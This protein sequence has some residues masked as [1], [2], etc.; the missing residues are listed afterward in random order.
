M[1]AMGDANGVV[2]EYEKIKRPVTINRDLQ[3]TVCAWHEFSCHV[4]DDLK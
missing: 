4:L 1:V 3:Q 2:F